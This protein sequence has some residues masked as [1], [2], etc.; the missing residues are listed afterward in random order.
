MPDTDPNETPLVRE[1]R[2]KLEAA[3]KEVGKLRNSNTELSRKATLGSAGYSHLSDM[4][5]TALF[6]TF[7]KDDQITADTIK[8]RAGALGFPS[9][10]PTPTVPPGVPDPNAPQGTQGQPQDPNAQ[11]NPYQQ[12]VPQPTQVPGMPGSTPDQA[13]VEAAMREAGIAGLSA[14]EYANVMAS[15]SG[16]GGDASFSQ[17]LAQANSPE[18]VMAVV[19]RMGPSVG[20]L[21]END[22]D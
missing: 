5:Q 20:L 19:S 15:R 7:G 21:N 2:E 13:T 8:E 12:F 9:S 16:R 11:V 22:V 14:A 4:Q 3:N 6:A 1:L 18:A 17:A 10:T